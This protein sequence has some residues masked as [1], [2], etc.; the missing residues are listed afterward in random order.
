MQ[1]LQYIQIDI[2]LPQNCQ[3]LNQLNSAINSKRSHMEPHLPRRNRTRPRSSL[4]KGPGQRRR[5]SLCPRLKM[6]SMR[7]PPPDHRISQLRATSCEHGDS[8]PQCCNCSPKGQTQPQRLRG[9]CTSPRDIANK[10]LGASHG[11]TRRRNQGATKRY[12]LPCS[13][14]QPA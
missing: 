7:D 11:T 14:E 13:R 10:R 3:L 5:N 12:S 2:L 8:K 1:Y 6:F 9:G 4:R